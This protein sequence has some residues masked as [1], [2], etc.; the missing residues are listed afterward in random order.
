MSTPSGA[1]TD[2]GT[3]MRNSFVN[4]LMRLPLSMVVIMICLAAP[5]MAQDQSRSV[6]SGQGVWAVMSGATLKTTLEGWSRNDGW[7]LVW[8]ASTDYRI[9]SSTAFYGSFEQVSERLVA[10]V[11]RVYPEVSVTLYKGNRVVHVQNENP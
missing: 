6:Q 7:E 11:Y 9:K 3:E 1:L 5:V 2:R 10:S 4:R 8:D